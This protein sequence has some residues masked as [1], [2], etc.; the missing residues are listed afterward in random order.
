MSEPVPRR[1]VLAAMAAGGL[2]WVAGCT[3]GGMPQ[4]PGST[5]GDSPMPVPSTD[6]PTATPTLDIREFG[7]TGSGRIDDSLGMQRALDEASSTLHALTV[8]D[9]FQIGLAQP[10]V[11][12][13]LVTLIGSGQMIALTQMPRMVT[14]PDLTRQ[15]MIVG[16]TFTGGHLLTAEVIESDTGTSSLRIESCRMEQAPM[17]VNIRGGSSAVAVR[18]CRFDDVD[19]GVSLRGAV[20]SIEVSSSVFTTWRDRGIWIVGTATA[21]P[22]QVRL[23]SNYFDPPSP[24]GKVRQPIQIN[25]DDAM[26]LQGVQVTNN[27]VHGTGTAFRD[28]AHPGAADLI[29][30]HRCSGFLVAGNTVEDGGDVGITV[31]RQSVNGVVRNNTSRRNN[32]VGICIGSLE[33]TRVTSITVTG[34]VCEDNGQDRLR[35]AKPWNRAGVLVVHG[36]SAMVQGNTLADTGGGTQRNGVAVVGSTVTLGPNEIVSPGPALYSSA[37]T[38]RRV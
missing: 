18:G 36:Q 13:P 27:V 7:L 16:M 38:V 21:A 24:G 2:G 25:G 31:S 8:P 12:P 17:G 29:S 28:P 37:S 19:V 30:L 22:R 35:E 9:G 23:D 4:A 32:T 15:A 34:N 5:T 11:L 6:I 3:S 20:R 10:L 33:S 26:L 14:V 1:S